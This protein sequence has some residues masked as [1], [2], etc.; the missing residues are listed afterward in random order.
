MLGEHHPDYAQ[1]LNN[2]GPLC[3]NQGD[4]VAARTLYEKAL[5]IRRK[6]SGERHPDYASSLN[7]LGLLICPSKKD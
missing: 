3:T 2:L 4:Y 7:N 1:S 5:A 6:Y